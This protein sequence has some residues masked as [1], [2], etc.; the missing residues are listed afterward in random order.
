MFDLDPLI[1][2]LKVYPYN[3]VI[4]TVAGG[5]DAYICRD[6]GIHDIYT[7]NAR[8]ISAQTY[9]AVFEDV[10]TFFAQNPA[11]QGSTIQVAIFPN[12]AAMAVPDASTA[13]PWRDTI[14]YM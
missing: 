9:Q 12:N 14:V 5:A 11:F 3:K 2:G 8:N 6:G 7:V 1:G 4:Q 10:S 13:Y